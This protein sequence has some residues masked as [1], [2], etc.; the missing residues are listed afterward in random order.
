[1]IFWKSTLVPVNI[2]WWEGRWSRGHPNFEKGK[3]VKNDR[4]LKKTRI[5]V[6]DLPDKKRALSLWDSVNIT[7]A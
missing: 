7:V 4:N 1:M 3:S 6:C 5:H 2:R